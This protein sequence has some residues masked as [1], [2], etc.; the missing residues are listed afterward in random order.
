MISSVLLLDLTGNIIV[1]RL[2]QNKTS[3]LYLANTFRDKLI[4]SSEVEHPPIILLNNIGFSYIKYTELYI[5]LTFIEDISAI[6]TLTY[7]SEL[8]AIIQSHICPLQTTLLYKHIPLIQTL[9]DESINC[10]IPHT[11][12]TEYLSKFISIASLP[13]DMSNKTQTIGECNTVLSTQRKNGIHYDINEVYFNIIETINILI[14]HTGDILQ[15][16]IIGYIKCT[17]LLSGHPECSVRLNAD[18]IDT[19]DTHNTQIDNKSTTVTLH[20]VNLHTSVS[21]S[22]YEQNHTI[23]FTPPDKTFNLLRYTTTC[24]SAPP[25]T[26]LETQIQE[27]SQ[28]RIFIK[29]S[30]RTNFSSS[31]AAKDIEIHIPC[32]SN[33]ANTKSKVTIGKAKH[34]PA[35]QIILWKIDKIYGGTQCDFH[36]E[37]SLIHTLSDT[38]DSISS[39]AW[40][41]PISIRF[42]CKSLSLSGLQITQCTVVERKLKYEASRHI[43]NLALAGTYQCRV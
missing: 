42:R 25:I 1:S 23:Q 32:P 28:S 2:F 37:I 34:K 8:A 24:R 15:H 7:I 9:I 41:K 33:T 14:S 3:A 13:R 39:Q 29:F 27:L 40:R 30:L 17:P 35:N 12:D 18:I 10:D 43:K 4:N 16:D 31:Y 26:L 36:S 22:E 6:Q 20:S 38:H 11:M 19:V 5:I 21:L